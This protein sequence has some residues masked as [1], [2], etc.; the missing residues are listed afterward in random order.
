M[1]TTERITTEHAT[2]AA[3]ETAVP[4]S[5]SKEVT[6]RSIETTMPHSSLWTSSR[7]VALLFAVIET[8]LG[9]RFLLKL[10]GANA[11]Q[12]LAAAIYAV[13][14]PLVAPFEGIFGQPDGT[15]RFEIATLLAVI[16]FVMLAALSMAIVRAVTGSRIGPAAG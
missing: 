10:G 14:G 8:V 9:V 2:T 1:T 16:C 6:A 3:G 12:P 5:T 7:L 4:A 15:A 11:D 13:T